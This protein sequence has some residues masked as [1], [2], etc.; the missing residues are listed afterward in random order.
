MRF[1]PFK[2]PALSLIEGFNR[3]TEPVL[4]AAEGFKTFKLGGR[5]RFQM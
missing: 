5:D 3:F 4:S 1:K 2:S